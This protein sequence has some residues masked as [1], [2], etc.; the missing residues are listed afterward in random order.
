MAS[1]TT[2]DRNLN[3]QPIMEYVGNKHSMAGEFVYG[4]L[5]MHVFSERVWLIRIH[6]DIERW[7]KK[8]DIPIICLSPNDVQD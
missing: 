5:T 6:H 4:F 8:R 2:I 1:M 7:L 3:P